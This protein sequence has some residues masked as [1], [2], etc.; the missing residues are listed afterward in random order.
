MAQQRR[1]K[2]SGWWAVAGV[3]AIVA[4]ALAVVW[5]SGPGTGVN[6]ALRVWALTGYTLVFLS[7]L[8]SAFLRQLVRRFG[9]P[10]VTIH[11]VASLT[12]LVVLALHYVAAAVQYG[13]PF[14]F[15]QG[16]SAAWT[17]FANGGRIALLLI[18]VAVAAAWART[19]FKSSWRLVHWLNYLAFW[20]ATAHANLLGQDT[21][22][23]PVRAVTL[24]MAVVVVWVLLRRRLA[25]R[26]AR[27][28]AA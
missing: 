7:I 10:F 26:P 17:L 4:L 8:S 11:H 3:A 1:K 18:L 6:V 28:R 15:V 24:A 16:P 14:V 23:W 2:V 21:Q 13:T 25:D 19:R 12:G 5:A 22:A 27:G 9:R 20:V